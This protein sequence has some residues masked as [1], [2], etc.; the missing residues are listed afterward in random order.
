MTTEVYFCLDER[1]T[2]TV[3]SFSADVDR[4]R[5]KGLSAVVDKSRHLGVSA[6]T[7]SSHR[8][9]SP[10][11]N[12]SQ[13]VKYKNIFS[14]GQEVK[15]LFSTIRVNETVYSTGHDLRM[16]FKVTDSVF[17]HYI[18]RTL[19]HWLPVA[20]RIEFKIIMY[21]S[22]PVISLNSTAPAYISDVLQV[23]HFNVLCRF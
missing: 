5:H 8:Q 4:S 20:A 3:N 22:A 12:D 9:K 1:V 15:K 11:Q 7:C 18:A 17:L 2:C 21:A 23:S 6:V 14:T 13:I 16:S 10:V 19:I